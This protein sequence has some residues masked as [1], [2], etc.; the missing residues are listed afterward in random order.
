MTGGIYDTQCGF[1]VFRGDV[2]AEVFRLARVDG[3]A[4][5]VELIYLLLK[6]RLDLKRI[7]VVLERNAPSSVRVVRDSVD[8]RSATSPRSAGTGRPA[9]TGHRSSPRCSRRS[10]A[11]TSKR[12]RHRRLRRRPSRADG[13]APLPRRCRARRRRARASLVPLRDAGPPLGDRVPDRPARPPHGCRTSSRSR[14]AARA[15]RLLVA[16]LVAGGILLAV[17]VWSWWRDRRASAAE[18]AGRAQWAGF[19]RWDAVTIL[20]ITLLVGWMMVSTYH[21]TDGKL[22]IAVGPVERLR[23]DLRDRPELRGRRQLPDRVSALRRRTDPLPLP[24]LLPGRQPDPP[25]PRPGDR[26]QRPEHRL[27]RRRCW[28]W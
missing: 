12:S 4:I 6:Y 8:A 11:T 15:D 2:A 16:D 1:K 18:E 13:R 27:A 22:A 10:S 25:G 26:Q 5:D 17:V 3:F 20:A 14:S 7:P 24:L 9:A 23:T 28:S 21:V 19:D